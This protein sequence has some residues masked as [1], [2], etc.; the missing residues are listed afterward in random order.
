[1]ANLN[2]KVYNAI[3]L[4]AATLESRLERGNNANILLKGEDEKGIKYVEKL[5]QKGVSFQLLENELE[6]F[7]FLYE[8]GAQVPILHEDTLSGDS[9]G[10]VMQLI[11][12]AATLGDYAEG[13]VEGI[14]PIEVLKE[15]MEAS[16]EAI[17]FMHKLKV[18]HNDLH[19]N[20]IVISLVNGSWKAY[21]IDFGWSYFW[22]DGIPDWIE[23]ERTWCAD[24]PDED[25]RY[26]QED[27]EGRL[28]KEAHDEEFLYVTGMLKR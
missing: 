1:M 19:A 28:P 11:N 22:Q 8:E 4:K 24:G 5:T 2:Q 27:I 26:L 21:I 12:N 13:Y 18:I 10:I 25:L 9:E 17:D 16:L 7:Q 3:A 20:N 6:I 15:I 23:Y 14:V